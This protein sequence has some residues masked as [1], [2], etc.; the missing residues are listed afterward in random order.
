LDGWREGSS[1]AFWEAYR[2]NLTDHRLWPADRARS[3]RL[4]DFF[5]L[6]KAIYEIGYELANRPEWIGVPLAGT[7]RILAG[8]HEGATSQKDAPP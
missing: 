8:G 1:R 6:E 7:L 3:E 2:A 4:L 5:M